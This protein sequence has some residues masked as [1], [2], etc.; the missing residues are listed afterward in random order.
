MITIGTTVHAQL[1]ACSLALYYLQ[2]C[3]CLMHS[4]V[5]DAY[6]SGL[7]SMC[8]PMMREVLSFIDP[9]LLQSFCERIKSRLR[10]SDLS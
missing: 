6:F 4:E 5:D 8:L 2:I 3:T 9:L 7:Y 1:H 10:L